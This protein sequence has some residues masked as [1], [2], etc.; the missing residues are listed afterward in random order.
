M[1]VLKVET[2]VALLVETMV[3]MKVVLWAVMSADVTVVLYLWISEYHAFTL[4]Q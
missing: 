4:R 1:V 3:A 2:V